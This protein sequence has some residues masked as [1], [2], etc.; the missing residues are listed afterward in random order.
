MLRFLFEVKLG[1]LILKNG[2]QK[3][4]MFGL[5][6]S[7]LQPRAALAL[8]AAQGQDFYFSPGFSN[9]QNMVYM[10]Y[11]IWPVFRLNN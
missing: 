7:R 3:V 9:R 6:P 11:T 10:V 1:R 2:Q 8:A 5:T 4:N